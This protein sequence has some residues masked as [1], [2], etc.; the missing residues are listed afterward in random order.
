[1]IPGMRQF[2]LLDDLREGD[3]APAVLLSWNGKRYIRTEEKVQVHDF[4]GQRGHRGDRGYAF[5]STESGKWEVASGLHEQAM[6][7]VGA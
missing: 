1:M 2:E 6:F 3:S 7:G 5:L 4:V